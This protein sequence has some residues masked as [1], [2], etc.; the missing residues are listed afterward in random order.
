MGFGKEYKYAHDFDEH[1]VDQQY[2]PDSLAGRRYYSP[3]DQGFEQ[4]IAERLERLR[5]KAE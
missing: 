2:L 5:D 3:S 4:S 1:Y